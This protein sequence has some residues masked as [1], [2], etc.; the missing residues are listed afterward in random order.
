MSDKVS[1][2][3]INWSGAQ[4]PERRLTSLMVQAI[5]PRNIIL[6]DSACSNRALKIVRSFLGDVDLGFR[7][8]LAPFVANF[9]CASKASNIGSC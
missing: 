7:L 2:I 8:R 5:R 4:F 1:I 3:I 6:V 9:V